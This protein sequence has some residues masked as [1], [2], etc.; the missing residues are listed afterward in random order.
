MSTYVLFFG[1]YKSTLT[2][3]KAWMASAMH[4]NP[5]YMFDGYPF[6]DDHSADGGKAITAFEK[7][8]VLD[9]AIKKVQT[10]KAERIFI[11]GHSSGCAIANK[12]DASLKDHTKIILVAL[13]G[14]GPSPAQLERRNTQVWSAESGNGIS[15]NHDRMLSYIDEYNKAVRSAQA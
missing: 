4:Y 3:I 13:D 2:D 10:C 5:G 15:L 12:V 11:V 9:E 7:A 1:G 8:G 6:P 14:Y